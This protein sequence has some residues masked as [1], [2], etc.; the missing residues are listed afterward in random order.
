MENN[1]VPE[2]P[3]PEAKLPE[4]VAGFDPPPPPY[5]APHVDVSAPVPP[6]YNGPE[7][8]GMNKGLKALL[9][10]GLV[11]FGMLGGCIAVVGS[12]A[13]SVSES[14]EEQQSERELRELELERSFEITK[15]E[16]GDHFFEV[17]GELTNGSADT[18]DGSVTVTVVDAD[19][20]N[21][22]TASLTFNDLA[23]DQTA[24]VDG[25]ASL[26]DG[27]PTD[28]LSCEVSNVQAYGWTNN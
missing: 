23:P 20:R 5:R 12:A 18:L 10:V 26:P 11:F 24:L 3:Q 8:K 19:G 14:I 25:I 27:A 28:G 4:G 7:K 16:Q 17:A 2:V 21:L 22:E 9:I 15:C 13:E 1:E 6:P